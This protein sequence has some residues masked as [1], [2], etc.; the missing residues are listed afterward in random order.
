MGFAAATCGVWLGALAASAGTDPAPRIKHQPPESVREGVVPVSATIVSAEGVDFPEV[1]WRRQGEKEFTA[2]PM[3]R[4]RGD[5]YFAAIPVGDSDAAVE[6]FIAAF[7][8]KTSMRGT[9]RS[10]RTP[11]VLRAHPASRPAPAKAPAPAAPGELAVTT[12]P[13]GATVVISAGD[14]RLERTTP[15]MAPVPP[16]RYSGT[17]TLDGW[18]RVEFAFTMPAGEPRALA[19]VLRPLPA[20]E[21]R[22]K[23]DAP[24]ESAPTPPAPAAEEIA[25]TPAQEVASAPAQ[26]VPAPAIEP[27]MAPTHDATA[28]A[29]APR[30]AEP[31]PDASVPASAPVGVPAPVE[32]E[33][34]A[35]VAEQPPMAPESTAPVVP[36]PAA[37]EASPPAPGGGVPAAVRGLGGA[38]V[39]G[40]LVAGAFAWKWWTVEEEARVLSPSGFG[41]PGD[42]FRA[43]GAVEDRADAWRIASIALGAL[44]AASGAG[45]GVA[46]LVRG[47]AVSLQPAVGGVSVQGTFDLACRTTRGDDEWSAWLP[48]R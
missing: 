24:A 14:W 9:W 10:E 17:A 38:A 4:G 47:R 23:A 13:G 43:Y 7:S 46:W 45:A 41:S 48:S 5:R 21:P 12:S 1:Y 40:A 18:N 3:K 39:A 26:A 31:A 36:A 42:Y 15:F 19:F 30:V 32:P 22:P 8:A 20:D 34:P 28:L 6:Y 25:S 35:V 2:I 29:D 16:G 27:A 37:P 33:P 11:H 44:A